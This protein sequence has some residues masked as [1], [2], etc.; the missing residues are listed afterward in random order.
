M[1]F[2]PLAL[3]LVSAL[4]SLTLAQDITQDDIPQQCSAVCAD[5]VSISRRCDDTTSPFFQ[6]I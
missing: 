1:L 5:V 6:G 2:Q 3:A 4:T